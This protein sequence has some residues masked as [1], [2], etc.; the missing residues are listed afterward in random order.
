[1]S[2]SDVHST[3]SQLLTDLSNVP[4]FS[5]S[6]YSSRLKGAIL[7]APRMKQISNYFQLSDDDKKYSQN[8]CTFGD[9]D[10]TDMVNEFGVASASVVLSNI[11]SSRGFNGLAD[12]VSS[13]CLEMEA[14]L[15]QSSGCG[16]Q[17]S[18]FRTAK[19]DALALS[20]SRQPRA[21]K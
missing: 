10:C 19:A 20:G 14:N 17:G 15:T 13:P 7:S 1:M 5:I 16:R 8:N 11:A 6:E 3:L 2:D 21:W 4:A 12:G 9:V 18:R